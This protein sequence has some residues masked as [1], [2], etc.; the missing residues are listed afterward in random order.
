MDAENWSVDTAGG[1]ER[2]SELEE[3]HWQM[4]AAV[5]TTVDGKLP[6]HGNSIMCSVVA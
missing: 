2:G 4:H 3:E 6:Q 1:N 5:C